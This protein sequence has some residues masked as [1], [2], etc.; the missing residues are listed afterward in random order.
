[1]K[2]QRESVLC[3]GEGDVFHAVKSNGIL[4]FAIACL[5]LIQLPDV[6]AADEPDTVRDIDGNRYATIVIASG[7]SGPAPQVWMKENLDV[8]RY[9]NGDK[10]VHAGSAE[11]WQQ[12]NREKKG[13]WCYYRNDERRGGVYGKLYNWYAVN[14]PRGLAPEGWHVPSDMEWAMLERHLGMTVMEAYERGYRG[15]DADVGGKLKHAESRY[16]AYPNAGAS[17]ESGFSAQPGGYRQ[18]YGT[19][20]NEWYQ[21]YFWT[22]TGIGN[23]SA[24]S[25][26]LFSSNS[27]VSRYNNSK[28]CGFSVR[29]IKDSNSL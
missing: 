15:K 23:L 20:L 29:C 7:D 8:T 13:A 28:S 5:V 24:L 22:S 19:F 9:R 4:L 3:P 26:S 25:R 2:I 1:M 6:L 11:E 27:V 21:A 16:W 10:I 18:H 17:N 12:C 14:D